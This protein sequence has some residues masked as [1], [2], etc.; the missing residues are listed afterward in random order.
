MDKL[1]EEQ[2]KQMGGFLEFYYLS[3][4]DITKQFIQD[5]LKE[6]NLIVENKE[7]SDDEITKLANEYILYNNSKRDWVIEGMK[8]YRE[9]L[10]KS[11]FKTEEE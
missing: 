6:K 8:L 4:P 10:K 7:L 3:F 2:K 1:T 11:T 5:K 9:K